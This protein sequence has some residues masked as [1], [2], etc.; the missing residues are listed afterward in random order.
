ME[1]GWIKKKKI[2]HVK[3]FLSFPYIFH[4]G[5]KFV[6]KKKTPLVLF[7]GY[8]KC[9][10]HC[11]VLHLHFCPHYADILADLH[12]CTIHGKKDIL[13]NIVHLCLL[14]IHI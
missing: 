6:L 4:E 1:R 2:N 13:E 9:C 7:Y 5:A 3:F 8:E 12:S 11:E 10:M 14:A